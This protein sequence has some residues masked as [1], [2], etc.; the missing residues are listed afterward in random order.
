MKTFPKMAAM[1]MSAMPEQ[2]E[3]IKAN[4]CKNMYLPQL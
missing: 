3:D 1:V 4:F 2:F